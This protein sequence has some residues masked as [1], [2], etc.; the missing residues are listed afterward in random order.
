MIRRNAHRFAAARTVRLTALFAPT[1]RSG[2]SLML[3]ALWLCASGSLPAQTVTTLYEFGA[4]G[5][6]DGGL[7]QS[8]D[9]NLYAGDAL[10]SAY[11]GGMSRSVNWSEFGFIPSGG[12]FN[13]HEGT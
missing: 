9:G 4:G 5:N 6:P 1:R 13:P 11:P 12:R 3:A 8:T 10:P 7:L 2:I